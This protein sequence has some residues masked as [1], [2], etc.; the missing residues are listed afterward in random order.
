M[1]I[2][3]RDA[4]EYGA[5]HIDNYLTF[6]GFCK[7]VSSEDS[8]SVDIYMDGKKLDTV[9]ADKCIENIENIYDIQ[10]HCF[11]FDLEEKHFDKSHLL[12]F[13]A[14]ENNEELVNSGIQT[15]DKNHEKFEEF[16]LA[17]SLSDNT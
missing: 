14:S 2:P 6:I 16:K 5:V 3:K 13:K 7:K 12:E 9:V 11:K 4:R 1:I 10:G 8:C 17:N 15:I